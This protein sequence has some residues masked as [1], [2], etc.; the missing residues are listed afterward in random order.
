M[1]QSTTKLTHNILFTIP[2][3][4]SN[5]VARLLDL[6]NQPS[7]LRHTR[8]GYLFL[9]ALS[10]RYEHESWS[11]P[12][13]KW[14]ED[15]KDGMRVSLQNCYA[16]WSDWIAAANSASKGTYVKEH[17][18]WMI[19]PDVE[20]SFIHDAE[21]SGAGNILENPTCIPDSFFLHTVR[22]TFLIRHPALTFPSLMRT[23]IDNEGVGALLTESTE[24][25]MKWEATY[26]WHVAVYQFLVASGSYPR[27]T[28]D[29]NTMYPIIVDASDLSEPLFVR[30]YAAAVELDPDVVKFEWDVEE[31]DGVGTVEARMM[32][33]LMKSRGVLMEKLK[34]TAKLI[35]EG[36]KRKWKNEFG[37]VLGG[38]VAQLVD[39]AM[40]DYEW[41][42]ARRMKI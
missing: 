38:R 18:N 4:A 32:D 16:A 39:D 29:R 21:S 37:E 33:T 40:A 9:P 28:H 8:D 12:Y 17:I 35:L 26:S 24:R 11:K 30:R 15:E 13:E 7:I 6:P 10:Y 31:Q 22:P 36:D 3:T 5:L 19:R 34:S 1:S 25:S 27:A 2:R 41:L 20:S 14:S 42:W 23:A